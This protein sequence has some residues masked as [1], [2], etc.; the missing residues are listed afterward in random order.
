[1]EV[2][3]PCPEAV[4]LTNAQVGIFVDNGGRLEAQG[5]SVR[6]SAQYDGISVRGL[7]SS[8]SISSCKVGTPRNTARNGQSRRPE[9][10]GPASCGVYFTAAGVGYRAAQGLTACSPELC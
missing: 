6:D 5:C 8:A 4:L 10:H 1:M 2:C 9:A 3:L 7:G